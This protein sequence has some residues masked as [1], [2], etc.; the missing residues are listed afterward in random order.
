MLAA[1]PA[2]AQAANVVRT[3]SISASAVVPPE[4]TSTGNL[5]CP[6]PWVALNGAVTRK[7][8]GIT[9]RRS[10]PGTEAGDWSFRFAA[11]GSARRRVSTV[12][13]CVRLELPDG[14]SGARLDV[15]TRRRPGVSIPVGG[16]TPVALRC[17]PAWVATG[18]GFSERRGTVRLASVVPSAHG[19]DFVLEN[20]GSTS[21]LADVSARCL[22]Q[23]V[24]ASRAGGS[25]ELRFRVA[26]PSRANNLGTD[27]TPTFSHRCGANQFSLATGSIVDPLDTVELAASGPVRFG[28]GRWTFRQA[29]GGDRVRT[30]LVCLARGSGFS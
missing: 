30:F 24:T 2:G 14:V 13:R 15:K 25:T 23:T 26:R 19:W 21:A 3:T 22:K 11:D 4:G 17:G 9:V 12:L 5:E 8:T 27:R 7:G 29:S 20:T 10:V 6:S 28:W 16:T 1:V 18:Y